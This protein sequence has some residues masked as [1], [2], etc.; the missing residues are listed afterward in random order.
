MRPINE[1]RAAAREK[2]HA[3]SEARRE[4][5]RAAGIPW[6]L[7]EDESGV[8]ILTVE[9]SYFVAEVDTVAKGN[10]II[11]AIRALKVAHSSMLGMYTQHEEALGVVERALAKVQS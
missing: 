10:A 2:R 8:G 1:R 5:S 7:S 4:A 6:F 9:G 11:G 3:R